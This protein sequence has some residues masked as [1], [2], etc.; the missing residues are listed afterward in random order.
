MPAESGP[1]QGRLACL[2]GELFLPAVSVW[3]T[4]F[5]RRALLVELVRRQLKLRYRGTWLGFLW[6]LLNP[7]VFMVVYT[8]VLSYFLRVGI[9]RFPA[10]LLTGLLPWTMWFSEGLI[11]GTTSLVEHSHFVRNAVFPAEMFPVA[12]V[13]TGMMNYVFSLPVL[14]VIFAFYGVAIRITVAA[15]PLVM[16]AQ[17]FVMVGLVFVTSTLDVFFR[18]TR[19]IVQHGL[20]VLFFLTPIMYDFSVVPVEWR[21]VFRINPMTVII[22]SYRQTLYYGFWPQWR[23]LG[24]VLLGGIVF[25]T[26]GI[27]IFQRTREAFAEHL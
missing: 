25:C 12:A 15:L 11:S 22:D 4:L 14:I 3:R 20:M 2:T 8:L 1:R 24:L 6:T 13:V 26:L 19:F 23:N 5:E 7:L 18:D 17:F 10:F 9:P 27:L 21:W 16:L